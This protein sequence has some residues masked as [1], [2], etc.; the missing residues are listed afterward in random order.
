MSHPSRHLFIAL[1]YLRSPKSHS[2]INLISWVAF[3]AVAI[4]TAALVVILSLH[5]G[6]SDT[7]EGMY[8]AFDSPIRITIVEG[9][10]FDPF[11][12]DVEGV[13]KISKNLEQSVLLKL[14]ER[15]HLAV[16]KGVDSVFGEV[17]PIKNLIVNGKY[18]MTRGDLQQAVVGRGI[19]YNLGIN[20]SL[21]QQLDVYSIMPDVG[22]M[23]LI[24]VPTFNMQ[25]IIP[26]GV[27]ANDEQI[28]SRYILAPIAFTQSLL[29]V[30]KKVSSLEISLKEG[31]T[32]DEVAAQIAAKIGDNYRV[33]TRY[34]QKESLYR[35][36]NQEKW[37]IYLLLLMV[38]LIASL[39]LAGNIVM[40]VADKQAQ[41][42]TLFVMGATPVFV[43]KIF[44]LQGVI[45]VVGGIVVGVLLGVGFSLVQQHYGVVQMGGSFSMTM[46]YPV[47]VSL[48]DTVLTI[49]SVGLVGYLICRLTTQYAVS[50]G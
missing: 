26:V 43:R 6:L 7:I 30:G 8:T 15:E 47:R 14:G 35:S 20:T 34:Q 42:Q 37:I 41:I 21:I 22:I 44:L 3:V 39:S 40:L 5:N 36:I 9:Q 25:T 33:Q 1:R 13:D 29:G 45:I 46:A 48:W 28:D 31:F 12:V 24:P 18:E 23:S 10:Y 27:F 49:S 16:I 2:V 17:V 50:N 38:L 32:Q 4:P 11:L 19:A